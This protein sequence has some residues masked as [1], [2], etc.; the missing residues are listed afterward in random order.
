MVE[1]HLTKEQTGY[2]AVAEYV[3]R[4]WAHRGL[5]EDVIVRIG[6]SYDGKSYDVDNEIVCLDM[7]YDMEFDS[8]WWEGQEYIRIYGIKAVHDIEISGGIYEEV[9]K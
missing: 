2:N 9:N 3:K 5:E 8:D 7:D 6:V 1:I 4:Y